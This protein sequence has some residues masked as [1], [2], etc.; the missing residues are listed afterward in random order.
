M[1][2]DAHRKGFLDGERSAHGHEAKLPASCGKMI[3]KL[4]PIEKR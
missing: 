4:D 3:V 1:A 2:A